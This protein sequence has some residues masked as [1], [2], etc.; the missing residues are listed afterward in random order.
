M[1]KLTFKVINPKTKGYTD[2]WTNFLRYHDKKNGLITSWKECDSIL[3]DEYNAKL[4]MVE[5]RLS[6]DY[7]QTH[8]HTPAEIKFVD[9][10]SASHFFLVFS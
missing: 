8:G 4:S 3:R 9:E 10:Q 5:L 1:N 6:D 2:W 7:G